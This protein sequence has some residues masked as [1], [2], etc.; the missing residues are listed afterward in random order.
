MFT[1]HYLVEKINDEKD[2]IIK[3]NIIEN[4]ADLDKFFKNLIKKLNNPILFGSLLNL[5][6][7]YL[8][9]NEGLKIKRYLFKKLKTC[10]VMTGPTLSYQN[11]WSSSDEDFSDNLGDLSE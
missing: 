4:E 5:E 3:F 9:N 7:L 10:K 2:I 1:N 6:K 8:N 11:Y